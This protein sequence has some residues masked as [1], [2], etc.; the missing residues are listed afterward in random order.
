MEKLNILIINKS[1]IALHLLKH[2]LAG[3]YNVTTAIDIDSALYWTLNGYSPDL[4]IIDGSSCST[5]CTKNIPKRIKSDDGADFPLLVL[6][7]AN[8]PVSNISSKTTQLEAYL[9]KPFNPSELLEKVKL[10]IN[11][12]EHFGSFQ[13]VAGF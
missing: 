13:P 10:T 7:E 9:N 5:E 2:I 1:R 11:K 4:L 8:K 3:N 12:F 6:T